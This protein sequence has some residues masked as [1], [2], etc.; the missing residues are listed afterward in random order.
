MSYVKIYEV[1]ETWIKSVEV[2]NLSNNEL[3][4]VL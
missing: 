3:F 2:L 4:F 1:I